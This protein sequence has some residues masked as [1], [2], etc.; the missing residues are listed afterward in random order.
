MKTSIQIFSLFLISSSF[1]FAQLTLQYPK[2]KTVDVIDDYHGVQV[3]DPYRWLED[4]HSA[5][6]A[7]WIKAQNELSYDYL[8]KIPFKNKIY[9]DLERVNNYPKYLSPRK[10][11]DFLYFYKNDGMQ[12]QSVLYRQKGLKGEVQIVMDPNKLSSDGTIKLVVFSL[13]KS[14]DYAVLG[15]SKGGSD[16]WE[17]QIMNM[18]TLAFLDDKIEWV[19]LSNVGWQGNGFY[20]SRYAKPEGSVL[21]AKNENHL[22]FYHTLGTRQQDDKLIFSD[23]AHPQRFHNITTTEDED[24]ALLTIKDRGKGKDGNGLWLMRRGETKFSPVKTQISGFKYNYIANDGTLFLFES[25]ENAPNGKILSYNAKTD[26]WRDFLPEKQESLQG[27]GTAGGKIFALYFK[28]VSTKALV[29]NWKGKLENEVALPVLGTATGFSGEAG[30]DFVFYNY[31]S[32]N[33]PPTIFRYDLRSQKSTVFRRPEMSFKPEDYYVEQIFYTSK[34]G[35]RIPASIIYKKGF[36]R[37]GTAPALM[38]AYGGFGVSWTPTFSPTR[39]AFLDQGG[40]YIQPNLRGGGEYGEQWH[41]QGTKLNK[42][43]VFDDFI[44]C[45]EY[46][47]REKY[48]SPARLAIQGGSNGGLLLGAVLNQRPELFNVAFPSIGVMDMLRFQKFTVGW[49]WT[50]EFGSSENPIEFKSLYA[51]SP[52]HNIREGGKYPAM[53]ITT[54]DHDDRVVPAH[55]F[56]YAAALQAKAGASSEN[57]LLLRVDINSGHGAS[58]A[59]KSL[60]TSAFLYAF[61]FQNMGLTWK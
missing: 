51:Y 38:Y 42:Q 2:T 35:T 5:E 3:K 49:S 29:Y 48:T 24:F 33:Y 36:K 16:W 60:E 45:A 30:D 50:P 46:M 13:S 17:Y 18:K 41:Q 55:S 25:N 61:M 43:N 8:E 32:L 9:Q 54:A 10:K 20:Y 31:T 53:L 19:K 22:V 14:G 15:F 52:L 59:K 47:I 57:P 44:A 23:P 4:D 26:V 12:N 58:N 7:A 34:D 56:K 28:D 39:I 21:A 6:T 11:G 40:V 1:C 27:T 37:D